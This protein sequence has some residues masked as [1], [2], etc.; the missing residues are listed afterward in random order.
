M[1]PAVRPASGRGGI[2][3]AGVLRDGAGL[4]R[5]QQTLEQAPPA[6]QELDLAT[7]EA[8]NLH[9]VSVLV[10]VAALA[11]TESRGC[12]RRRDAPPVD[13]AERGRHTVIQMDT[14]QPRVA[15][16]EPAQ[17]GAA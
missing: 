5:L 6:G 1:T 11:R 13:S 10:T 4:T 15:G 3:Y 8:A 2:R 7:A 14:G 12:H 16:T 9:A 17:A